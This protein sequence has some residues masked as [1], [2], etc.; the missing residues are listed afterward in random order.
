MEMQTEMKKEN[1]SLLGM[2]TSPGEQFARI[3]QNPKI[4]APLTLICII[5]GIGMALMALSMNVETLI[6]QGIPED[7]A[8]LFLGIT[9]ITVAVTGIVS[10]IIGIL[11][12]SAIYLL[13]AKIAGS[14]VT[15]K[16]LFSLNTFIMFVGAIGLILNMAIRYGIGGN[17]E[18][19]VTSLAG[20]LNL[21]KPGVL[22]SIEVFGIWTTILTALGLHKT[23]GF[24]KGLAWTV[25]IIFFLITIGFALIGT[26]LQA[27]P[28]L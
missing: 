28:Q 27:A 10:P 15:F 9:R 25:A 24:S 14:S 8:E 4:W 12:S 3:K 11:I 19:Y 16:Q 1:P 22:G 18:I 21:D 7:Q 2:F 13:I 20:V 26:A 17:P 5:F 6:D 23:A